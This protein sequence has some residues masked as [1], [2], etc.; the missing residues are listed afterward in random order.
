MAR[1]QDQ[2]RWRESTSTKRV[3][4]YLPVDIV[5]LLDEYTRSGEFRGRGEALSQIIRETL[6]DEPEPR[7]AKRKPT[8]LALLAPREP[9]TSR[10]ECHTA[11]GSRC[12]GKV[13]AAGLWDSDQRY[14]ECF[15][16]IP[17]QSASS[18][19]RPSKAK[20]KSE[21]SK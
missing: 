6:T 3:E 15:L 18:H 1:T 17:K 7:K 16:P 2:K 12:R 8:T 13:T 19:S 21:F 14:C 4:V 9:D 5:G 20:G 10:C 11:R